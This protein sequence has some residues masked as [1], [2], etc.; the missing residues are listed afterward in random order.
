MSQTLRLNDS[1][2]MRRS[3]VHELIHNLYGMNCVELLG[4]SNVGKSAILRLLSQQDVWIQELGEAGKTFTPVYIDCNRMLNVN[5]QGFYE[6]VL[7]CLQESY[8]EMAQL[9]ELT[10]AYN[11]LVSPSS[12][13]QVPLSFNRGVTAALQA[14]QIKLVFLFDE[15]DEPFHKI[16]GRVFLNLRALKDRFHEQLVYMTA[17]GEPLTQ[18]RQEN[19]CSE[20]CELFSLRTWHLAPLVRG[21]VDRLTR[22]YIESYDVRFNSEDIDFVYEWAGGHP[23]MVEGICRVLEEVVLQATPELT[24]PVQRWKLHAEVARRLRTDP[25]LNQ[26][27]QKIWEECSEA[28]KGELLALNIADHQPQ[29]EVLSDLVRRHI[30]LRAGNRYQVFCRLLA[31]FIQRQSIAKRPEGAHLWVDINSGDVW[32]G[33]KTV[34]TLTGLEYKLILFLFQNAEKIVDK[35]QIVSQVWG[36]SYIDEVD[37]ARIEKLISRLRQKIEIDPSNPRFLNTVRG[38]GYRFSIL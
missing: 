12:D 6:L 29:T 24:D 8:S 34:D 5:A 32:V 35:Y 13:F 2:Y 7:R 33:G 23:R 21:D 14:R 20:F 4:F 15:F 1:S 26:E 16:D 28:E 25:Y 18:L 9:S 27:C 10:A 17:T 38:R 30:L 31:E 3:D 37:D 19:H 22:R 11:L 36:E